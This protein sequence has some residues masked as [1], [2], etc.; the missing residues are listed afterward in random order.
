MQIC[1]CGTSD[2]QAVY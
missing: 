1:S 2:L